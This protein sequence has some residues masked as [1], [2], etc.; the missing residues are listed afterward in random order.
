M[1]DQ[2]IFQAFDR[3]F[4]RMWGELSNGANP[5]ITKETKA[6]WHCH[7]CSL[8]MHLIDG[9]NIDPDVRIRPSGCRVS[10]KEKRVYVPCP[11][12]IRGRTYYKESPRDYIVV[13]YGLA[14]K[15]LALGDLP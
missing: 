11:A 8:G 10:P 14:K 15:I 5:T 12:N 7:V 3:R 1:N 9:S 6:E 2:K 13:D 4:L